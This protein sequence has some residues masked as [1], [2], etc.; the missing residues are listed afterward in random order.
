MASAA[1]TMLGTNVSISKLG[2]NKKDD[3]QKNSADKKENEESIYNPSSSKKIKLPNK[4][5]VDKF[6]NASAMHAVI[7]IKP[8][9]AEDLKIPQEIPDNAVEEK[10]VHKRSAD[11]KIAN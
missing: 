8:V 1:G 9:N 5:T 6:L 2:E 3:V 10:P 4:E 11:G 7:E